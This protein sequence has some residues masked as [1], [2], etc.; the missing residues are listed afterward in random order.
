MQTMYSATSG[1]QV[2]EEWLGQMAWE[3]LI[4]EVY[5]TPK[6]GLVD[7]YS[8][9]AHKDMD[10]A[11]F[12]RSA[13]VLRPYFVRMAEAGYR[14]QKHPSDVF[15]ELRE[16]GIEAE[17]AMYA[18]TGNVNTHKGLI[19]SLGILC[20][21]AA[22]CLRWDGYVSVK[23]LIRTEQHMVRS[24]LIAELK[25]IQEKKTDRSHG[26]ELYRRLGTMG[27]RGEAL[28]GYAS[29]RTIG[30]PVM[31]EGIRKGYGWNEIKLQVLM[32]FMAQAEDTNVIYR[33][34][35]KTLEYT[36]NI[37]RQFLKNGGAY[38][39]GA[40]EELIKLDEQF[41]KENISHGGCADLLAITIF[42]HSVYNGF[43][44]L[45]RKL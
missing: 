16:I 5:T 4:E 23:N 39:K 40:V 38:R 35:E 36:Q 43:Q 20:A 34:S 45:R 28:G 26:E 41:I 22:S 1:N 37:A 25:A 11:L 9:G 3:A 18:A 12:E 19:F 30:L 8:N 17:K 2:I 6:P 7:T 44:S 31:Q 33:T 42:L 29:I 27:V 21:A 14:S 13:S 15:P 10:V 32:E 24:A